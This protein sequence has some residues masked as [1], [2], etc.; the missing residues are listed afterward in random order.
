MRSRLPVALFV[1]GLLGACASSGVPETVERTEPEV[2]ALEGGTVLVGVGLEPLRDGVVLIEDGSIGSI[3]RAEDVSVPGDARRIDARGLTLIPGFIDAHVHIGFYPPQEVLAG[4]VT[5]V[6]DLAWPPELIFPLVE[7]S[8][9]DGFDGPTIHAAGPMIT[10]PGGYPET[11]GWAPPGTGA[12]ITTAEEARSAVAAAHESGASVIKVALNP[13]AG[14]TLS[15]DLLEQ[16]VAAAHER[17]LKVTAHIYGLDELRKAIAAGVD[18]LAHMLMGP[19]VIPEAT[20]RQIVDRDMAVVPTLSVRYG[21][22]RRTAIE[23]LRRFLALGGRVV[24]GTDLGNAGPAP[25]IDSREVSAMA[26]A[27]MSNRD[28][29][30]S[31]TVVSAAWLGLDG[32]GVLEAGRDADIVGIVGEVDRDLRALTDVRLVVRRGRLVRGGD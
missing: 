16:V 20:L 29:I 2:L 27:G 15:L 32:V 18:E 30:R 1:A 10:V 28:I 25:G 8:R 4:G 31:A 24:Y 26:K 23:N 13:P 22:D 17:G 12:P 6:R 3:G 19:E 11:A 21:P 14:P 5:T 7:R 9:S